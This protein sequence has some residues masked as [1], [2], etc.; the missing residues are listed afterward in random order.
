M[1]S[2]FLT[3]VSVFQKFKKE[4]YVYLNSYERGNIDFRSGYCGG[5][6]T[7]CQMWRLPQ[8]YCN[9]VLK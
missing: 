7:K 8:E 2:F 4:N 5:L 6:L 9:S 1:L 3:T